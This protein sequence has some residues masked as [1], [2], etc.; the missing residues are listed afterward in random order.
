MLT[1]EASAV[2][3]S[4]A[5]EV[6]GVADEDESQPPRLA[7]RQRTIAVARTWIA[8][9]STTT[10]DTTR[11]RAGVVPRSTGPLLVYAQQS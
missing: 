9:I 10:E 3:P 8:L 11:R 7:A 4:C 2:E 5:F 6:E 1:E